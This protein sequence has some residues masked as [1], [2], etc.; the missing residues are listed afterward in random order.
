MHIVSLAICKIWYVQADTQV[1]IVLCSKLANTSGENR[2]MVF[3]WILKLGIKPSIKLNYNR[4]S[5]TTIAKTTAAR[6]ECLRTIVL[7]NKSEAIATASCA[8]AFR[9][10]HPLTRSRGLVFVA[11]HDAKTEFCA[12]TADNSLLHTM[13]Y[14]ACK[15][16]CCRG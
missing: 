15:I 16:R 2:K 6:P 1:V 13:P 5:N 3:K 11:G 12:K 9:M 4:V 10:I 7:Y 14:S 8:L